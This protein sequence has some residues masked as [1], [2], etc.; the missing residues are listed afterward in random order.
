MPM[1]SV[2]DAILLLIYVKGTTGKENEKIRGITRLEK[3]I[4][5]L[6]EDTTIGKSLQ[7]IKFEPYDYGPFSSDIY[8]SLEA[9]KSYNFLKTE[10]IPTKYYS[11]IA[12]G[13]KGE[14]DGAIEG[15][16]LDKKFDKVEVYSL[17]ERGIE[18]AK[19]LYNELADEEREEIEK[20]KKKFNS[21]PFLSLL[22]YVYSQ[23]PESASKSKIR[24]EIFRKK[25]ELWI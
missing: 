23:Y 4:F 14:E 6:K 7:E 24:D 17:N 20:I 11:E 18:I 13:I 9:L 5:L 3:L 19:A 1:E 12:D 15:S 10:E 25:E 8:D 21:I 16:F 2:M 22:R